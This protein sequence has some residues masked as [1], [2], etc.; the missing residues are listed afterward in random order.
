MNSRKPGTQYISNIHLYGFS[1]KFAEPLIEDNEHFRDS[2]Y[3][4]NQLG[5]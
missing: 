3:N 5:T 4:F 1:N 2:I